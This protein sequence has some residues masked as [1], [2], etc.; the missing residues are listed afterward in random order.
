MSLKDPKKKMS[1]SLGDQHVINIFDEPK[2]IEE[3][4]KRAVTSSE[5]KEGSSGGDNLFGLLE[6]F[7]NDDSIVKKYRSQFIKGNVQ[8]SELKK[9]VSVAIISFFSKSRK[10]YLEMREDKTY[11][12][13]VFDMGRKKAQSIATA[14]LNETKQKMGLL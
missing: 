5:G 1:K 12:D 13:T 11:L 2:I 14:T 10:R 7:K 6:S 3:K 9:S 8:F 4:I